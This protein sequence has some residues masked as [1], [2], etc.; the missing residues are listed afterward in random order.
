M[1]SLF[2]AP[3][4][5]PVGFAML[6]APDLN[7]AL[8]VARRHGHLRTP[9]LVLELRR[10][11]HETR[12]VMRTQGLDPGRRVPVLESTAVSLHNIAKAVTGS[13]SAI[14]MTFDY[15]APTW[16]RL[17]ASYLGDVSLGA[18]ETTL[19]VAADVASARSPLADADVH[20]AALR[21]LEGM[22]VAPQGAHARTVAQLEHLLDLDGGRTTLTSAAARL[23]RSTRTIERNL[24]AAGTTF[25]ELVDE[26]RRARAASLLADP[27]V[28]LAQVGERVGYD[29]AANFGRACRRW[30]GVSP[31]EYRRGR[32]TPPPGESVG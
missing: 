16:A 7:A 14:A 32:L 17:Y 25:R 23:H 28:P 5:G 11:A 26:H 29:D 22:A 30:F 6:S 8:E 15:A 10:S 21:A 19:S 24:R 18:E 4:H 27:A 1:G 9:F 31:R 3:A 12:L 20:A 2:D 13:R